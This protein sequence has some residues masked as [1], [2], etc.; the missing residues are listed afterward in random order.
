MER[1]SQRQ[2]CVYK[3]RCSR[4]YRRDIKQLGSLLVMQ[5]ADL[6]LVGPQL[7]QSLPLATRG[8]KALIPVSE[9]FL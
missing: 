9:R 6:P 7:N 1:D 3:C 8:H 4:W 2:T 5:L